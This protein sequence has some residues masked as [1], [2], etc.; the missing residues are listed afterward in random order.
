MR[1]KSCDSLDLKFLQSRRAKENGVGPNLSSPAF[2]HAPIICGTNILKDATND[3][4]VQRFATDTNQI[5]Q[6]FYSVD[7]LC[8]SQN[9]DES[10]RK[11]SKHSKILRPT[12]LT[13]TLKE[14]LWNSP[15]SS[16]KE[17]IGGQL[18]ICLG[19]PVIIK[20]NFATELCITNGQE[21]VVAGWDSSKI[22]DDKSKLDTLYVRLTNPPQPIQLPHL[23]PNVVPIPS[24][25]HHTYFTLPSGWML[26]LYREQVDVLPFFA[27]TDYASQGKTR[28][29]NVVETTSLSSCQSYY[30]A[31]S[32]SS[33]AQHTAIIG[34][35][36][37]DL[38]TGGLG[39]QGWLRQE[40]RHLEVLDEIT[41]L[42]YNGKLPSFIKGDRRSSLIDSWLAWRGK[43]YIPV[44]DPALSW[45]SDD[46][47]C[48]L[49]FESNAP[50]KPK[51]SSKQNK[52]NPPKRSKNV[53]ENCGLAWDGPNYSCAYDSII[54]SLNVLSLL[55]P[56]CHQQMSDNSAPILKELCNSF[57][58]VHQHRA[59]LHNV[60]EKF[61]DWIS[62][63]Y[64]NKFPRYGQIGTV[65][66]EVL[67]VILAHTNSVFLK[68][69]L[70]TFCG[71]IGASQESN[72]PHFYANNDTPNTVSNWMTYIQNHD[73]KAPC[74]HL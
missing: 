59:T 37:S 55:N 35:I 24:R 49:N 40:F 46:I 18:D 64:P 63:M 3:L 69:R 48:G 74:H 68:Q 5:L 9:K 7:T 38:I 36:N 10:S 71:Y 39:S 70:C 41:R 65:Y 2:R 53:L 8:K 20:Y 22:T 62:E 23:P 44:V 57:N 50:S 52:L 66:D 61:R 6:S 28:P 51:K 31:L 16:A 27:L 29:V 33:N 67:N 25:K 56:S 54:T 14:I 21:A 15:P 60:H 72:I 32:R 73:S 12:A 45:V 11:I 17:L 47:L 34:E 4:G 30:T 26:S 1:Y 58:L 19:M 42:R 13:N 43:N